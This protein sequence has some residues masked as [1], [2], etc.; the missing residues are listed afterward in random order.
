[1]KLRPH[2]PFPLADIILVAMGLAIIAAGILAFVISG[3]R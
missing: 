3:V 1:M 2:V